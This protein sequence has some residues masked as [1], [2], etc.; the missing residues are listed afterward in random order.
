MTADSVTSTILCVDDE[1]AG[2]Y[3]RK[4]I[5]ERQG[6]I[7][8]TATSAD[9][10][11]EL[12][13]ARNIDLVVTDHLMGRATGTKMAAEIKRLKPGVPIILLSG[14]TN[15]P[16][17][18]ENADIFLPKTEGPDKLLEKVRE[19]LA[20]NRR[21]SADVHEEKPE[22]LFSLETGPL[23]S[24]L[25]AIVE[26]SDDAI[27]SKT[28][29]GIITSWNKAAERMYGYS[30]GE[31]IGKPVSLLMPPDRPNE[32]KDI[33][34]RLRRGERM[35]HLQARRRAKDGRELIVE[36]NIS[37]IRD[38]LGKIVGAS[39]TARDVTQVKMAEQAI[40]SSEKLAVAGRMAATVAHEI[41]NP[42]EAITNILYLL[43]NSAQLDDTARE[44]VR[45]AQTELKRISQITKLTLGFHRGAES[46]QT[47]VKITE[48][49]DDVLTLY[50]RKVVT[51][52]IAVKKRYHGTGV[53]HADSGEL[54]QVFSNLM[55]NAM[56]ALTRTGNQLCVHVFDSVDWKDP[57]V[58]G[59]RT[60]VSDNGGGI[61]REHHAR[62]FE[63]FYTTKG[64]KGTGVGLW[65]SRSII[66]KH[67]GSI[68]FRS[69]T[70][71]GISGTAFSVFLPHVCQSGA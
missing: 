55:V 28:L 49:I 62:L 71:P 44:F 2:L 59:V 26:S 21:N 37:P 38:G 65:V 53:V 48:L 9:Q 13:K 47:P 14:T 16:E 61:A 70:K 40:R 3:F 54:R 17:G 60:V 63:P 25:A 39:T 43:E 52:G 64:E 27:F 51:L 12:F 19:L 69:N 4:L 50:E 18:L 56:D 15:I 66:E 35:E 11:L 20:L 23:Q 41:N 5:L 68:R 57:S 10:G 67:G 32:M 42:L 33:L 30:V 8:V 6:Y 22:S 29:D 31:V 34:E 58:K 24:L 45:A 1:A 36:L 46:S 7:V